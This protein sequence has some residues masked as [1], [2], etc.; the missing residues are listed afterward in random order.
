[1]P[2]EMLMG[3]IINEWFIR[4]IKPSISDRSNYFFRLIIYLISVSCIIYVIVGCYREE[5]KITTV[6]W[7]Y[8]NVILCQLAYV[9]YYT[10]YV[11]LF[12]QYPGLGL[13]IVSLIRLVC[14]SCN[15]AMILLFLLFICLVFLL[16]GKRKYIGEGDA[17]VLAIVYGINYM[18]I[19]NI[20]N[21]YEAL[22]YALIYWNTVMILFV[23]RYRKKIDWK[24]FRLCK[25]YPLVPSIYMTNIIVF[26]IVS[27]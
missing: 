11:Y 6:I 9:D 27:L 14:V 15:A 7:L 20:V 3:I 5:D 24:K 23:M 4:N 12:M 2:E 8:Y 1:M 26:T 18:S 22:L 13:Y 10:G 16:L 21:F 25:P 19:W 17:E